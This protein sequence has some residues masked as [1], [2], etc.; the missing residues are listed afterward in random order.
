MPWAAMSLCIPG[1]SRE[2]AS[3]SFQCPGCLIPVALHT[4]CCTALAAIGQPLFLHSEVFKVADV[5]SIQQCQSV[6]RLHAC[7]LLH[8][9][10]KNVCQNAKNAS[11]NARKTY[12]AR[13]RNDAYLSTSE[14]A[15]GTVMTGHCHAS[16][17]PPSSVHLSHFTLA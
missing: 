7:I 11:Q 16:P 5:A 12:I 2:C 14:M 6:P 1:F 17:L 15:L 8:C 4:E 9:N 10:A 3:S 13:R